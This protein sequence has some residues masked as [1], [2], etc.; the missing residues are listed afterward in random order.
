MPDKLR[1]SNHKSIVKTLS[2]NFKESKVIY[3]GVGSLLKLAVY[4]FISINFQNNLLCL[5]GY[6]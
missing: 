5:D 2:H 1:Q 6:F 3:A 4:V